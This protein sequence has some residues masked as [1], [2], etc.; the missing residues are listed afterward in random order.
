MF[1]FFI[2]TGVE[3]RAQRYPVVTFSIM[4]I[5][6]VVWIIETILRWTGNNLPEEGH[7]A[8]WF[9]TTFG[10]VPAEV[11]LHMWITHMFVHGG[12]F[13][14]LG[15]MIYLFLFGS[16]VED[17]MGRWRFAMFYLAGGVLAGLGQIAFTAQHFDSAI[18][19]V[20]ASGA[21]SG[22][23]GAFIPL[24][25]KTNIQFKWFLYLFPAYVRAGDFSLKAWFV[26]SWWFLKDALFAVLA[27]DAGAGTAF[28]AHAAGWTAGLL[29]MLGYKALLDKGV[30]RSAAQEALA[31][32]TVS[33]HEALVYVHQ[34]GQP[35]GPYPASQ[36]MELVRT[37]GIHAEA[38]FWREGMAEWKSVRDARH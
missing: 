33:H 28:A 20:G 19:L 16:C 4:G 26:M 30:V 8:P 13:H 22:C 25:L 27:Y 23:M 10:L 6:T 35:Y 38:V 18:P 2:P 24:F 5:C 29:I 37:G 14:L 3:Y 9:F 7:F 12:F 21:I 34:A 31:A 32:E 36:F 15:N 1:W 11:Q 17:I